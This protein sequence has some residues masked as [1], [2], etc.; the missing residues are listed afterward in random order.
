M[1]A[2][3][4]LIAWRIWRVDSES[5]RVS[6]GKD[7]QNVQVHDGMSLNRIINL[8]VESGRPTPLSRLRGC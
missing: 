7:G 2:Y 5:H 8:I 3:L 1:S 6:R 4:A